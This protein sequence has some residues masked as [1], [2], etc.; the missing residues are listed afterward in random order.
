MAGMVAFRSAQGRRRPARLALLGC[1]GL[2]GLSLAACG[3]EQK[4]SDDMATL[5]PGA[6]PPTED[7][8][9]L[10]GL[11]HLGYVDYA[12]PDAERSAGVV[13]RDPEHAHPGYTLVTSLT[14]AAAM[15][16]DPEGREVRSWDEGAGPEARWARVRLLANGDLL[17]VSPKPDALTRRRFDGTLVWRLP[18]EVHHDG[19]ELPDGRLLVLTRRF[20]AIPAVDPVRR[21][22]DNLL[23]LVSA[24]G[25]VLEEHS[26]YDLL[27]A[28]PR[29]VT[30]RRPPGLE[31]LPSSFNIDPIHAN[32]VFWLGAGLP[33][34][35]HPE[36]QPGRVLVTLRYLDSVALIDLVERRC[37][38]I[39]G[40]GVLQMPHDGSILANGRLLVLDNGSDERGWSRIVEYDPV[41]AEIT[42]EYRS[43]VPEH[44][45]TAGRG[46]VQALPNG[47][48]LVGNSNS[49]EAF[50]VERGGGLVWR[51]LN[52]RTDSAGARSV[53]RV[54]RYAAE[55][56]E[57]LLARF[58][59]R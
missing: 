32:S 10:D 34:G 50:E 51:Y 4:P 28:E 30:V 12:A 45:Y 37:A 43:G 29:L 19:I 33:D 38:W 26:L 16:V 56:V 47:N 6:V 41:R 18:L 1:V 48:V 15:L 22:V 25:T 40:A 53:V 42:W 17:C 11:A 46:T 14:N 9:S 21:S 23:T 31:D 24:E 3:G 52:P 8:A 20:R 7:L 58:P 5:R 36:F 49:G 2:A 54:E 55:F 39:F 35:T 13:L 57:H 44:F 59:R 27:A